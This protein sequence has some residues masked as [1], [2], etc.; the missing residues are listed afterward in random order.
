MRRAG[1]TLL[2]LALAGACAP[3]GGQV[4]GSLQVTGT[5]ITG[6][7]GA[8]ILE[9]DTQLFLSSSF[10]P[11]GYLDG[12]SLVVT[13]RGE[14][15]TFDTPTLTATG[16]PAGSFGGATI[17]LEVPSPFTD[18]GT[19]DSFCTANARSVAV[20]AQLYIPQNDTD[21]DRPPPL[22]TVTGAAAIT[23]T[24]N[25]PTNVVFATG[26]PTLES[27]GFSDV[28]RPLE[29][30]PWRAGSLVFSSGVANE[31][32]S[33]FTV[34]EANVNGGIDK[35]WTSSRAIEAPRI[36][37][38]GET[39]YVAAADDDGM[40]EVAQAVTGTGSLWSAVIEP[41]DIDAEQVIHASAISTH[42]GGVRVAVQASVTLR[43]TE[44]LTIDPPMG[45]YY[46][47]FLYEY[48]HAGMLVT[49]AASA[50]DVIA[51]AD[52]ED[53]GRI[54]TTGELPPREEAPG[55]RV[56]RLDPTGTAI[57][58][59]EEPVLAYHATTTPLPDGGLLISTEDRSLADTVVLVRLAADGTVVF[60]LRA[61]GRG[62]SAAPRPDG[63]FLWTFTGTIA[64]LPQPA[65]GTVPDRAV[66][67]L[68]EVTADGQISR[69]KQLGCSGWTAVGP[70]RSSG[71]SLLIGSVDELSAMGT[72]PVKA[73]R[74]EIIAVRVE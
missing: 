21:P 54:V 68:L 18:L 7:P 73:T 33:R 66:P 69:A 34:F 41:L 74:N 59:H 24:G 44:G 38:F 15:T 5:K 14:A 67:L 36:A 72:Q 12:A 13:D 29:L 17:H 22:V 48:D 9:V 25:P 30:V 1:L 60:R 6:E 27:A 51:M 71:Y 70:A 40:V 31:Y 19:F 32:D 10:D 63:S 26:E 53:G 50:R 43:G 52:L 37:A 55:L 45:K 35:L 65:N 58:T 2:L 3:P 11:E 49:A 4:T 64:G 47:S 61:L 62:G 16:F 28:P 39:L 46:G 23:P 42:V 8:Q 57:F 20:T 56:E